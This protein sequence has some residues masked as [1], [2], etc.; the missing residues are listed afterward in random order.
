LS[1]PGR[2]AP[3]LALVLNAA[4]WGCSWWPFRQLHEAGLHPLWTTAAIYLMAVIAIAAIRPAAVHEVAR[5][6]ALWLIA[7]AS[8]TTNATFNWGVTVGDVVR[9]VLLFYLMPLWAVLLARLLLKEPLTGA[10]LMRV[11]LAL[12]GALIVLWPGEG[13][14]LQALRRTDMLGLIGGFTFALSNVLLRRESARH[15]ASRALAMFCG[16]TVVAGL[17]AVSLTVQGAVPGPAALAPPWWGFALGLGALFLL[18]NLALQ[19]GAARLPANATAVIMLTEVVFAA[20]TAL[21][22]GAGT[23]SPALAVGGALIVGAALL[24]AWRP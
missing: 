20:A 2:T 14:A 4:I 21:A 22:L 17:L 5:T 8:G 12:A 7:L 16:G 15:E 13:H 19:Y 10:A 23:L 11:A 1:T 3:A 18:S 24:A 6:P 9:V